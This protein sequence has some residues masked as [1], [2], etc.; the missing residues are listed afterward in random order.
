MRTMNSEIGLQTIPSHFFNNL[1]TIYQKST[2]P[3]YDE[4]K[5][6]R[7]RIILE[8]IPYLSSREVDFLLMYKKDVDLLAHYHGEV[9]LQIAEVYEDSIIVRLND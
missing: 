6:I 2:N 5:D 3:V 8:S 7:K 9:P 1:N 4:V